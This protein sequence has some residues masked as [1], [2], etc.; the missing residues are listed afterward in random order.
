MSVSLWFLVNSFIEKCSE[1]KGIIEVLFFF[2]IF[3][4]ILQPQIIDSL[5]ANNIFLLCLIKSIVGLRP[6]IPGMADIV[7]SLFFLFENFS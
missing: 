1:S 7:M 3:F 6:E 4:I 5:L 2:A